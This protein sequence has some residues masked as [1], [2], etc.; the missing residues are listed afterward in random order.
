[1]FKTKQAAQAFGRKHKPKGKKWKVKVWENCDW[2]VEFYA[3]GIAVFVRMKG[4]SF[5][6]D[7]MIPSDLS[8]A[9]QGTG[10]GPWTPSAGNETS[11]TVL[12]A[13]KIAFGNFRAVT[14]QIIAGWQE[15]D[16]AVA[17]ALKA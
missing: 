10:G 13:A 4:K 1:M 16:A 11:P 14:N 3:R 17:E 7:A 15:L 6:F 5:Q 8:N 2:H 9:P 12:G